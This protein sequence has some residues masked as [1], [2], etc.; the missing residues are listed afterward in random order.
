MYNTFIRPLL[1]S[2]PADRAHELAVKSG[3]LISRSRMLLKLTNTIF[4][5]ENPSLRQTILGIDFHNPVGLA[6]G[7]D[8]NGVMVPLFQSL[9]FGFAEIGSI[10]A[11]ASSGNPK[12][13]SF[14]LPADRSLINRLGLNN[15]GVQAVSKRI[16]NIK[17]R[18][19]SIP[20]GI[21]IAKTHDPSIH[22][23]AATR[24]YKTSF[25]TLKEMADYITINISCP[26]TKE[27]KTF[28]EPDTLDALLREL[29]REK[30][31]DLPPVFIKFSPDLTH[32]RLGELVSV[33]ENHEVS[34]YV[35]CN[36]SNIREG[37]LTPADLLGEIGN[38]GLSG[39]AIKQRSTGI[40]RQLRQLTGGSKPIIGVGGV[41]SGRDAIEKLRAGA[42]LLQLY[43]A[44][45]YEGPGIANKINREVAGYLSEHGH[46]HIHEI[47]GTDI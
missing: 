20:L 21:N 35:A 25:E 47:I 29:F 15:E 6:A 45:V 44:L 27:G 17:N 40:I 13:R 19:L 36:T 32:E 41:A 18:D 39:Q 9:G 24:D 4:T 26:N 34:G 11:R 28:E 33:C 37:L 23:E 10:T 42:N 14:R 31:T 2:I 46:H 43:T 22:G 12:P 30:D 1:F 16:K 3:V 38:G 5:Q 7:F 8:K